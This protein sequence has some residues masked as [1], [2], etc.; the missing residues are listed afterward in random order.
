ML[1]DRKT[2]ITGAVM[3]AFN[4]L[5][6]FG[7]DTGIEI[8]KFADAINTIALGAAFIFQRLAIKKVQPG[9]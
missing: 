1:K 4:A 2:I 8:E 7:I 9:Q 3:I 5:R 6:L